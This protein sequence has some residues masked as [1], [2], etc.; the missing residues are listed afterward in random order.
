MATTHQF[1]CN[2]RYS[3]GGVAIYV[4]EDLIFHERSDI[5]FNAPDCESIFVEIECDGS[6]NNPVFGA[7]YKHGFSDTTLFNAYLGEFLEEFTDKGIRLTVLGD[8]NINLLDAHDS[9]VRDYKNV[10]N[11]VG[12]SPLINKPTRIFRAEGCNE[13]SSSCLDHILSNDYNNFSEAGILI[14][15]VSDHLPIF[16]HIHIS[17]PKPETNLL[18]KYGFAHQQGS[19]SI[20]ICNLKSSSKY[21]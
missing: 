21:Q 6:Q 4:S 15:D 3:A 7:M 9:A 5:Q 10:L 20:I 17:N 11:S 19:S 8:F 16:G 2:S 1:F 12:F 13:V 14:S 18:V